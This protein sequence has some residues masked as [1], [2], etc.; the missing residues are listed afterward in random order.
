MDTA[1]KDKK[2]RHAANPKIN[3]GCA[4]STRETPRKSI[5]ATLINN[6]F[7]TIFIIQT[8]GLHISSTSYLCDFCA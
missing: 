5:H 2:H 8:R 4:C 6:I 7:K 3:I 1:D